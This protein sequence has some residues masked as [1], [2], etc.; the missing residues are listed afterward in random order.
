MQYLKTVPQGE[1]QRLDVEVEIEKEGIPTTGTR[2][3][4]ISVASSVE[5]TGTA[6]ES[7]PIRRQ[8]PSIGTEDH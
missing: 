6:R 7:T 2:S 8:V 4:H 5:Q 1:K 3:E